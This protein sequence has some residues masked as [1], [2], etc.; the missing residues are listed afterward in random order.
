MYL[1]MPIGT[2][3]KSKLPNSMRI[4]LLKVTNVYSYTANALHVSHTEHFHPGMSYFGR[5]V[6]VLFDNGE[7]ILRSD[8]WEGSTNE[9][10]DYKI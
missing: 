3:G 9:G 5:Q 6:E 4:N 2:L 1:P 8:L 10:M 7:N